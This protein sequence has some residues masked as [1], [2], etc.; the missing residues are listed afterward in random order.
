MPEL[1]LLLWDVGGVIL[2][3]AWDHADRAAAAERFKLDAAELERRHE[4]VADE[5]EKGRI[6]EEEYLSKTVFYVPRPFTRETFQQYIRDR[7]MPLA[8]ALATARALRVRGRYVMATLN[9]ESRALN[10][11]RI[12][13]FHLKEIFHVFFSSC[14]TGLRKPDPAAYQYALQLAQRDPEESLL[15][16][17]RLDNV[18]AAATLGLRTL[19]VQDPGRLEQDLAAAGVAID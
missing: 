4:E 18:K 19:W 13:T 5:F 6:D 1:S 11:Y 16:D 12:A 8:H 14:Y 2:S 17:D 3:N 7:S 10:E 15:L 9:N